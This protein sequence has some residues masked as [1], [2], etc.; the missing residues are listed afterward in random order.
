MKFTLSFLIALIFPLFAQAQLATLPSDPVLAAK[1]YL[2]YDVTSNQILVDQNGNERNEPASITKLMTAYLTFS[3]LKLNKLSLNQKVT[4]STEALRA[5]G[6]ESRMFLDE[7]TP[8][9]IADLLRG[10]IVQSGNDAARVLATTIAGNEENFAKLMNQ[11]AQ[12]LGMSNTHYINATGMPHPQHYSSAY[13]TVLLAAAIVREFPEHYLLYS[14]RE[15]QYNNIN[16]ANRNRLLWMD[17]YV[18]GMKTGHTESAG[19]C[20]VASAKRNQRRLI[21]VVLGTASDNLRTSE[22]QKLLNYGFQNFE[23]VRLYQKNKPV[24][25]I[26]LW[27]GT[28]SKVKVGFRSDL[29]LSIPTG[30]IAQLKAT[31]ETQQPLIAPITSGQKIGIMK[32]TLGGKPYAEYKLVALESMPLANVFSRGWDSIRMLF[33]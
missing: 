2:L 32:I 7:R 22:S 13:D 6:T 19:F 15:F 3:A 20:L 4:P 1:S 9:S 29:F 11:E 14:L 23:T 31:M 26:L 16:Q 28:E 18:D 33:K 21:S 30:Q 5:Q 8:V 17:P 25:S 10:L 27:K 12:R 24:A